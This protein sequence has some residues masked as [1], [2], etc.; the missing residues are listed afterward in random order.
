MKSFDFMNLETLKMTL[1]LINVILIPCL[2]PIRNKY[3]FYIPKY[4][5]NNFIE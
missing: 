1:F 2:I 5:M 4:Y 3:H